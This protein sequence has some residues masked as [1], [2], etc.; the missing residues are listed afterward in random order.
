M[1]AEQLDA[2]Q[3]YFEQ[4]KAEPAECAEDPNLDAFI[5]NA[6][7]GYEARAVDSRRA[8]TTDVRTASPSTQKATSETSLDTLA[9]HS[10]LSAVTT[11]ETPGDESSSSANTALDDATESAW[12]ASPAETAT[13]DEVI[14]NGGLMSMLFGSEIEPGNDDELLVVPPASKNVSPALETSNAERIQQPRESFA[15]VCEHWPAMLEERRRICYMPAPEVAA[16]DTQT[17]NQTPCVLYWMRTILRVTHGNFALESALLLAQRLELPF[18]TVC[19]VPT[20]IVYPTCHASNVNDAFG[21]WSFANMQQQ[22]QQAGL[23][24]VGITGSTASKKTTATN[25]SGLTGEGDPLFQLFDWFA[26]YVVV[27]DDPSDLTARRDLDHLAQY[28]HTTRSTSPWA[29][30]AVDSDACVPIYSRLGLVQ[31][32]LTAGERYLGEDAFN[33]VYS[34]YY[35]KRGGDAYAFTQ[36]ENAGNLVAASRKVDRGAL[37]KLLRQLQLEEVDWRIVEALNAQSSPE[38]APFSEMDAL[39]KLD[40]LL[41]ESSDRPAIQTELQ[42]RD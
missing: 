38:M 25:D 8:S 39:Q 14:A 20:A 24:F 35:Q 18:V 9:A 23:V 37:S 29:L 19:F 34:E 3:A 16:S 6:D 32:T 40:R 2:I 21:R 1:R 36:L 5:A 28:L 31:R 30:L 15:T 7:A 41:A 13:P 17:R 22:F 27:T 33:R 42:V 26:P 12:I 4:Q 11:L 10:T